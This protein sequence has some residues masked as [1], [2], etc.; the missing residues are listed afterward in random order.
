VVISGIVLMVLSVAMQSAAWGGGTGPGTPVI[1]FDNA[2]QVVELTIPASSCS[3]SGPNCQWKFFLTEPSHSLVVGSIDGSSGTLSIPYPANYCG[4]MEAEAY[5]GLA[6]SPAV[7]QTMSGCCWPSPS[8]TMA[9]LAPAN[10]PTPTWTTMPTPA[11]TAAPTSAPTSTT[12]TTLAAGNGPVG[13]T[14]PP[15]AAAASS[16]PGGSVAASSTTPTEQASSTVPAAVTAAKGP[17]SLPFT[18]IDIKALFF[19]GLA[20]VALGLTMLVR[21]RARVG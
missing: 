7:Q 1:T 17:T 2:A 16:S 6:S 5:L 14:P 9:T 13:V 3:P 12:S 15:S 8:T 21:R 19:V 11:P 4:T 18:G 10:Q 20:L